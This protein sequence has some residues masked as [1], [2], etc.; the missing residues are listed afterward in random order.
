MN[1]KIVMGKICHMPYE[2]IYSFL[3]GRGSEY[4]YKKSI[5]WNRNSFDCYGDS[6]HVCGEVLL[7]G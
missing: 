4:V 5:I 1:R 6:N 3:E 7:R 2:R